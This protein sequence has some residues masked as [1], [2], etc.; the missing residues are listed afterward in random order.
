MNSSSTQQINLKNGLSAT[1]RVITPDDKEKIIT[2]FS[3]LEAETTYTRFF[4]YKKALSE[5]ELDK[6]CSTD[7]INRVALAAFIQ[8]DA[9]D[10]IIGAASYS[11]HDTS[12]GA[13]AAEVAFTIEED[14]HGQG[15][16]SILLKTL[17]EIAR[18]HEISR[19]EADVLAS[20]A[21]MLA[22][23]H[24]CGLPTT[25]TTDDGVIHLEMNIAHSGI[26]AS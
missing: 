3:K 6:A 22:V 13:R 23:F 11:A 15:L 4:S 16:A 25:T 9:S 26:K 17:I 10:V 14:Y 5:A 21:P 19:L 1:I 18:Q 20:N 24:R 2:A 12:D 7:F 8:T